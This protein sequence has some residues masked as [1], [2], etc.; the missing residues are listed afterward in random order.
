[1][2]SLLFDNLKALIAKT[3]CIL[4]GDLRRKEK[5]GENSES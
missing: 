3:K 2:P 1:M 5:E 4:D